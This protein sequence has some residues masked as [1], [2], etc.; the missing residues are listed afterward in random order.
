MSFASY[1]RVI[2]GLAWPSG[3]E[4]GFAVVLAEDHV[5]DRKI[6]TRHVYVLEEDGSHD[7]LE[8]YELCTK[9]NLKHGVNQ[10]F[11]DNMSPLIA[12]FERQNRANTWRGYAGIR[13][14]P[15]PRLHE[16]NALEMYAQLVK[17]RLQPGKKS[18]HFGQNSEIPQ[19]IVQISVDELRNSPAEQYPVLAAL[20]YAMAAI[21]L[22]EKK[23][24]KPH[25]VDAKG[26]T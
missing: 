14:R 3:T 16:R 8:L 26:W 7:V 21:D 1:R 12:M 9:F 6:D 2:G 4:E 24:A 23:P 22:G 5:P 11:G 13:L 19:R 18:L 17:Q 20:G 10:W 25:K 15:A